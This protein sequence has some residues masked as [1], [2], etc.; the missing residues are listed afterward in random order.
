MKMYRVFMTHTATEDLKSIA[1]YVAQEFREPAIAQKLVDSI[2]DAILSLKEMPVRFSL[3]SDEILRGKGLRKLML[4][5]YIVF[6]KVEEKDSTVTIVRI[7]YGRRN[8]V[9]LL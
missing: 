8:W 3:L 4:E 9:D 6:Y 5:N 2:K 1:R 7:L